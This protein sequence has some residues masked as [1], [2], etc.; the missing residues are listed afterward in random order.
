[1]SRGR[2]WPFMEATISSVTRAASSTTGSETAENPR[3]VASFPGSPTIRDRFRDAGE[4]ALSPS[5][6]TFMPSR[7]MKPAAFLRNSLLCR[8]PGLTTRIRLSLCVAA[9]CTAFAAVTVDFPHCL[10]QFRIT[11]LLVDSKSR[12]NRI[13]RILRLR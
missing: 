6:F 12:L 4:I 7:R 10:V 8:S 11:R 9:K 13:R 2:R 3:I 5:P 1:M